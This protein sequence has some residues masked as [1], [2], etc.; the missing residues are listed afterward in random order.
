[1]S[2]R[3]DRGGEGRGKHVGDVQKAIDLDLLVRS[4]KLEVIAEAAP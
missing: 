1:V 4:G 2:G 3:P